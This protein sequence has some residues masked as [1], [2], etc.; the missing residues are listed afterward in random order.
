MEMPDDVT[1]LLSRAAAGDPE[2]SATL[3]DV[4]YDE[5]KRRAAAFLARERRDHTLEATALVH[6]AYLK[7]AGQFDR[8]WE[9]RSHFFGVAAHL[10]RIILVDHAR[11]HHAEKRG[12]HAHR[13]DLDE[14]DRPRLFAPE[15]HEHLIAID[16]ALVELAKYDERAARVVELRFFGDLT[17][18]EAA[19]VLKVSSRTVK[20]DWKFARL[21]LHQRL[22][23]S[24]GAS[25]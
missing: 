16:D 19:E 12:G 17:S 9:N 6:E 10:M 20:N 2:A 1:L 7:L 21:W 4:V 15:Q 13:V 14:L 3:M 22:A 18:E 8:H 24:A 11:A 25:A 23:G 5:L